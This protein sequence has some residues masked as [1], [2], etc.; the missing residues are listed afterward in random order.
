MRTTFESLLNLKRW[1]EDEA[2]NR[3]ALRIRE[4]T[5]EEHRLVHIEKQYQ[6]YQ[7]KAGVLLDGF[8]DIDEMRKVHDH[9]DHLVVRI[10]Q[11]KSVIEDRKRRLEEARKSLLEASKERKIF[12]RL[13][14]KERLAME[15]G[16][17]K[18]EQRRTDEYVVSGYKRNRT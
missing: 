16:L 6:A 7:Q 3:V 12:E 2:K 14:E 8:I 11:Q 1:N 5:A 15:R 17:L 18:D 10:R 4:L 13:D 9:L